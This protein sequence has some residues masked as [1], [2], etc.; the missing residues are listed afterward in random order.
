MQFGEFPQ[1]MPSKH[2]LDE[3]ISAFKS[4]VFDFYLRALETFLCKEL[5]HRTGAA[6]KPSLSS[7]SYLTFS[8][9]RMADMK[10]L[11]HIQLY[12][13]TVHNLNVI[14]LD[15]FVTTFSKLFSPF[16]ID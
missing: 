8:V 2:V 14:K 13:P 12:Y 16:D 4:S 5:L 7:A 9:L 15:I 11:L 10:K 6:L 3:S 1:W